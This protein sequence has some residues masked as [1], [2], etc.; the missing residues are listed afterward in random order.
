[1]EGSI[2]KGTIYKISNED[3][4]DVYIGSTSQKY[5]SKR[6]WRH[7][8]HSRASPQPKVNRYGK[9]FDTENHK[10]EVLEKYECLNMKQLRHRE[11]YFVDTT[12]NTTNIRSPIIDEHERILKK[13]ESKRK[14]YQTERGKAMKREASKRY[15]AKL[16]IKKQELSVCPSSPV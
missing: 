10:C 15:R 8:V 3:C 14:Y 12:P 11:R 5:A 2:I 4:D 6:Y 1:M 16:K 7:K 13:K 9:I